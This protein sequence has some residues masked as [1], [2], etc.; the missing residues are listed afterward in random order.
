MNSHHQ[1]SNCNMFHDS[2]QV[3]ILD[4]RVDSDADKSAQSYL[5]TLRACCFLTCLVNT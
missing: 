5:R 1:L 3:Y 2:R 4:A